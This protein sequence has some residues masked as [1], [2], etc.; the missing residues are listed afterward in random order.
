M[1]VVV[2]RWLLIDD[3]EESIAALV[4]VSTVHGLDCLLIMTLIEAAAGFQEL[5]LRLSYL[6]SGGRVATGH[7]EEA[8]ACAARLRGGERALLLEPVRGEACQSS[9]A[10]VRTW[11]KLMGCGF[12]SGCLLVQTAIVM[13]RFHLMSLGLISIDI[14]QK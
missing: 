13:G 10:A 9:G 7:R 4:L 2:R 5:Q 3:L 6:I 14:V 8:G 11:N 12:E 1:A